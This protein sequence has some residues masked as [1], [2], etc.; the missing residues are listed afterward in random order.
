MSVDQADA[1]DITGAAAAIEAILAREDGE[2]VAENAAPESAAD[3]ATAEAE[4]QE[5]APAEG[6]GEAEE[7][8]EEG[9]TPEEQPQ[10]PQKYTVKIGGE[11][12][13]VTLDE[14]L[15]G[16][17]RQADYTRKSMA[18]AE[19]RK[20][21]ET[22]NQSLAQERAQLAQ[23]LPA[24]Q[25][26][27]EESA[28]KPPDPKLKETNPVDYYVLKNEYDERMQQINAVKQESE[29]LASQ[30]RQDFEGRQQALMAESAAKLKEL[31]PDW[32][33]PVKGEALRGEL[34]SYAKDLG[35]TDEEISQTFD[36]RAVMALNEG[37]KG[38]ELAKKMLAATPPRPTTGPK[39]AAP[40]SAVRTPGKVT[41][42][43]RLKQRL[44]QTGSVDDAASL[45]LNL[46][47]L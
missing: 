13:E 18:L 45:F 23:L 25:Q 32:A 42:Q 7:T 3:E 11:T 34:R 9:E 44:A 10:E 38:R 41:E 14:A 39:A 46:G 33:D 29:R 16:Y 36:Y 26:R 2:E 47:I 5:T 24:L 6:E 15:K 43:T 4:T 21:I 8:T 30:Q 1:L 12:Q 35:F 20:K 17:Q 22:E 37:R 28:P 27:L 40:G 31:I 19:D